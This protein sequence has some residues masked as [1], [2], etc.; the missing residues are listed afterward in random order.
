MQQLGLDVQLTTEEW[1]W[2]LEAI[3]RDWQNVNI[4]SAQLVNERFIALTG[5]FEYTFVG[6]AESSADLGL[7]MEY[8]Y[9]DRGIEATS[10]FQNDIMAGLR[11]AMNNAASSEA[12]LGIIYDLDNQEQ[13][14]SLEASTRFSDHWTGSLEIRGFN[15]I[16][17]LSRLKGI[18]QD[19]FIQLE[20]AY[21]F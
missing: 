1:L 7:V 6:I 18:E 4:T 19:D 15:K 13:L 16:D 12:L 10:F 20:A 17:R 9:D 11:L 14:I 3:A 21:H 5:G 8:L 2:K